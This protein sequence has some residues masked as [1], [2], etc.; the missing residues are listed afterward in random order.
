EGP[1]ASP[2]RKRGGP[3]RIELGG[4]IGKRLPALGLGAASHGEPLTEREAQLLRALRLDHLRVE[5][6]LGEDGWRDGLA[7]ARDDAEKLGVPLEA[8]LFLG[9]APETE[10]DALAGERAPVARFVVFKD[11]EPA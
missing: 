3:V 8:A 2:R 10:L 5:L 11:G 7:R 1:A 4:P 9:D 6:R